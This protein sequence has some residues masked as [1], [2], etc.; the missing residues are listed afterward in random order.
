MSQVNAIASRFNRTK[1][2]LLAETAPEYRND[3]ALYGSLP[4]AGNVPGIESHWDPQTCQLLYVWFIFAF[5][6]PN[7]LGTLEVFV[8][9]DATQIVYVHTY[10]YG[11]A[12]PIGP[13]IPE[14]P[15]GLA[16][17]AASMIITYVLV[18]RR[19]SNSNK[20]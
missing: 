2:L 9:Q 4:P 20:I 12:G 7:E 15:Y 13:S 19:T 18:R 1:G 16:L 6:L 5:A 11:Y 3:V 17:L 14:Y 10:P 8:N